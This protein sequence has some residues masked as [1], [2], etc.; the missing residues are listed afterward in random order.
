[1]LDA[2]FPPYSP[3]SRR[4]YDF[5]DAG[6]L[7]L[8]TSELRRSLDALAAAAPARIGKGQISEAEATRL[9]AT[10][11]AIAEDLEAQDA[12]LAMRARGVASR[13]TLL[14]RLAELRS[15]TGVAWAAKVAALRRE[16]E[17]RRAG[18]PAMI[19]KGTVTRDQAAQ[20]LERLEAVHDL[21][22]RHGFAFD[23]ER[24][25]LRSMTDAILDA[26]LERQQQAA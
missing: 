1:M 22:W 3:G 13:Q 26:D 4:L 7:G 23:G 16:L 19:D 25:E 21:Y 15:R 5:E 11:L 8:L 2:R 17:A 12:W 24:A 6:E 18:Y 10:W 14:E 9:A 20:Q